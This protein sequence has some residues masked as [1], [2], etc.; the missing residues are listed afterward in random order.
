MPRRPSFDKDELID[1]ATDLFWRR[2]WAGTS[3]KDLENEL[4]LKPGSFYA[5]FGSKDALFELALDRF[6][7]DGAK[8]IAVLVNE[9]GPLNALKS[10][11]ML[12]VQDAQAPAMACMLSKTLLE[13]R[14]HAHPLA[15]QAAAHLNTFEQVFADVFAQAQAAGQIRASHDPN[16]LARRY[17]SDLLGVRV[18][19]E[20]N[21]EGAA[22]I[23]EDI[24]EGLS[25]L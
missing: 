16:K 23:A 10:W 17:Q 6:A 14:T 4:K 11:P 5:A 12:S 1:R 13:L 25:S 21:P 9:I 18:L 24:A 8:A 2:G 19:A 15:D 22:E 7:R 20:H 3:L